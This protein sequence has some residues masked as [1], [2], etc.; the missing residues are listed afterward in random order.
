[1]LENQIKNTKEKQDL[2][3]HSYHKKCIVYLIKVSDTLYKFGFS[4]NIKKRMN[5]HKRLMKL[6]I[7]LVFCIES[8][9]NVELENKF[10][11]FLR[12]NP[13]EFCKR[14]TKT[15]SGNGVFYCHYFT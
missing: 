9:N 12:E 4:N 8:K 11:E 14:V 10:K 2:L 15:I 7:L 13:S 5:E 3:I 1:M 6:D